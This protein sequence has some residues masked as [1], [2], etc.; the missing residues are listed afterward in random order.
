MFSAGLLLSGCQR[1]QTAQL[2]PLA[3]TSESEK[4]PAVAGTARFSN[5]P[6]NTPAACDSAQAAVITAS[7]PREGEEDG[8]EIA[9][10][11]VRVERDLLI[12]DESVALEL[13]PNPSQQAAVEEIRAAEQALVEHR[14]LD[15]IAGFVRAVINDPASASA[16][17]GLSRALSRTRATTACAAACGSALALDA[18][19]VATRARYGTL[20]QA[21]GRHVDA[22]AHWRRV[23]EDDSEHREA[24]G[25]LAVLL[26]FTGRNEEAQ[27]VLAE[28]QARGDV[29]PTQLATL[30][31]EREDAP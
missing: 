26:Y 19:L 10:R 17:E 6:Q 31:T 30:L 27:A 18:G 7:P 2:K 28:A 20:L 9:L 16:F 29:V 23:V 25:R 13:V 1:P 3:N 15:A 21:Q 22:L 11:G 5:L 12:V 8:V 14:R 4:A 24:R